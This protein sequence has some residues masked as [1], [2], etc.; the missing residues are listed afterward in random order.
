MFVFKSALFCQDFNINKTGIQSFYFKDPQNRNQASFTSNAPFE[1]FTGV[2][3]DVWGEI[4]FDPNDVKNTIKGEIF[5]SVNSIQTGIELRDEDLKGIGWLNSE[6]YPTI[7]FKLDK[8]NEVISLDINKI[9]VLMAGYF[10]C[11]GK[12]KVI[13]IDAVLTFLEESELTKKRIS[14]DLLSVVSNF[15][16]YLSDYGIRSI[17][18]PNR[19]SDEIKVSVNIVG[20]NVNP[21]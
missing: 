13:T 1:N 2:V 19:V 10:S 14:G 12:E 11:R 5:I 21:E 6:K 9:R 17:F 8:V 20:T 18:I 4:S 7:S 15:D 3:N 16:I